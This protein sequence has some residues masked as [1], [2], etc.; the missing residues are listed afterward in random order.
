MKKLFFFLTALST[1]ATAV[2]LDYEGTFRNE[3]ATLKIDTDRK[4]EMF[5]ISTLCKGKKIWAPAYGTG[6]VLGSMQAVGFTLE[7]AANS[8]SVT[9]Q[10]AGANEKCLPAGT[11][12]RSK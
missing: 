8:S 7:Y 10:S 2:A 3:K 5:V 4:G 11:Y 12:I 1:A 6:N 9:V